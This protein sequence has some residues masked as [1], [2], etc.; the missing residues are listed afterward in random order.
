MKK[1]FNHAESDAFLTDRIPNE[2]T[3]KAFEEAEAKE[4][5]EITDDTPAFDNVSDLM[6]YL[7][8]EV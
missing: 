1:I 5:G 4:A 2:T 7:N 6:K 3:R 8:G